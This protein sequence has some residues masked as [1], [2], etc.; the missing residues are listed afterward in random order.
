[1]GDQNAGIPEGLA[2]GQLG[3]GGAADA[4]KDDE[5]RHDGRTDELALHLG[6]SVLVVAGV[7]GEIQGDGASKAIMEVR[8]GKN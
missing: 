6:P 4:H 1:M 8:E 7:V 3:A 5:G 2:E